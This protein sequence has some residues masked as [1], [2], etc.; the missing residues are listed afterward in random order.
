MPPPALTYPEP[1]DTGVGPDNP[2]SPGRP[3]SPAIRLTARNLRTSV[4]QFGRRKTLLDDVTLSFPGRSLIAVIGPSGSGKSTLLRALTGYQPA[5][6]GEVRYNGLDLYQHFHLLRRE[7]GFVPQDDILH[8]QLTVRAALRYAARLRCPAGTSEEDGHRRTE[9]VLAEL[10]LTHRGEAR[11]ATL[12]G[13][14]RKRVSVALELLTKPSLLFLDEPTSGLDPGLDRQV[15][16]MLRGLADGGRTVVLTTHAVSSLELCDLLLVLAP[17]G[18]TAYFG[19]PD[20]GLEFFGRESWADVFDDFESSPNGYWGDGYRKSEQYRAYVGDAAPAT[21]RS[22]VRTQIRLAKE[23]AGPP[24]GVAQF[25]TLVRRHGS[26]IAADRGYVALLVFLP[27]LMGILTRAVPAPDGF[28]MAGQEGINAEMCMP[29][30]NADASRV[31]VM[32]AVGACFTG[33][34]NSVRELVQE[35]VIYQRERATGLSRTA[36]LTSKIVVLGLITALQGLC[37]AGVGLA[38]RP[39]PEKGLMHSWPLAELLVAMV[40]L[41]VSSMVVGLV[42]SALVRTGEQTMPL[43]VLVTVFQ[44]AATSA[45]FPIFNRDV[46]AQLA[47]LAPSRWA[48]GAIAA[49]VDLSRIGPP[50]DAAD[51]DVTDAVWN[52]Q[53][54]Q[55]LTDC[56]VLAALFLTGCLATFLLLRRHE[57]S[58]MRRR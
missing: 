31:V 2:E 8:T 52:S 29:R 22:A 6:R 20:E 11:I 19:P 46:L 35:R 15:M 27:L 45:V 38:G 14:Q 47:W 51:L 24:G 53:T 57:P 23:A 40:M 5:D 18:R 13:G 25:R 33:M 43:L 49:T 7:I 17:G 9:Q 37:I 36:Y 16:E 39:L 56:G 44:A 41:S 42:V 32:L 54:T 48:V 12:S 28:M 26:V 58:A 4:R 34:A 55:W 30:F 50:A 1:P 3:E 10:G 21:T